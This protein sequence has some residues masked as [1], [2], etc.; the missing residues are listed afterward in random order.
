MKKGLFLLIILV[1]SSYCSAENFLVQSFDGQLISY[2]VFGKGDVTLVFVHGWAGD[3]RYWKNQIPYFAKK[4]RVV[5]ID[6]AG[7]GHSEQ[8]RGVYT[9]E[10]FGKDVKAVVDDVNATKVILI[11]HS[12]GGGVI[13]EA[14][15]LMPDKVIGL[16]GVDTLQN[17]EGRMAKDEI[18][19]I[20]AGL[21]KDFKGE[22]KQFVTPMLGKDMKPELRKWIIYDISGQ[23]PDIA[24]SAISEYLKIYDNNG[25]ANIFKQVKAPV[26]C[27][28]ADMR[29][30]NAEVN[31]KYMSS[32]DVTIMKGCG[33]FPMMERPREFNEDLNKYVKELVKINKKQK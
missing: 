11:G 9:L 16:V 10:A 13:A 26:R 22:V 8:T 3:S 14:A 25:L 33:H 2:N 1:L 23:Q 28:N 27:V 12:M 19:K 29:P 20:V 4:Y 5:A 7:Q 30:T 24:I 32:F 31:R 21:R 6:S 17:V 18:D 15:K